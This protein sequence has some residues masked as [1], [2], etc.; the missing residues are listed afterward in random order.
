M[1]ARLDDSAKFRLPDLKT[2]NQFP[3]FGVVARLCWSKNVLDERDA[4]DQIL[5]G[6]FD[7]HYCV[8]IG[9]GTWLETH[10]S[11]HPVA[12]EYVFGIDGLS[13]YARIKNK[14]SSQ[15]RNIFK[16]DELVE[17]YFNPEDWDF[18]AFDFD[19]KSIID[20]IVSCISN[21]NKEKLL[22]RIGDFDEM[23]NVTEEEYEDL[24]H[25]I[26]NVTNNDL[27]IIFNDL[28]DF[29][30]DIL[31][32][33]VWQYKDELNVKYQQKAESYI[34]EETIKYIE[35]YIKFDYYIHKDDENYK[36][37]IFIKYD[38]SIFEYEYDDSEDPDDWSDWADR[39]HST[40]LGGSISETL[41]EHSD[42]IRWNDYLGDNI[43]MSSDD[44]NNYLNDIL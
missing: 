28:D 3:E 19:K 43:Y 38:P 25:L 39:L 44:I 27:E 14:A 40:D 21:E 34:R 22:R 2:F 23:N 33:I 41:D 1:I 8:L 30:F 9:L 32:D 42:Q 6:A 37:L 24:E 36:E 20:E 15:L 7:H 17:T 31:S 12:N 10:F 5:F 16:D 29:N 4:P 35:E 11:K 18:D 26:T 13:D